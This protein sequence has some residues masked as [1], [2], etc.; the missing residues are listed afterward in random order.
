MILNF[1]LIIRLQK[2]WIL[3]PWHTFCLFC[4]TSALICYVSLNSSL[5]KLTLDFKSFKFLF[6]EEKVSNSSR[7]CIK[8]AGYWKMSL[9][10]VSL[11]AW[12]AGTGAFEILFWELTI[13]WEIKVFGTCSMHKPSLNE[14]R[15]YCRIEKPLI[16][17]RSSTFLIM[18]AL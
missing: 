13:V 14:P 12:I 9:E 18:A 15:I 8:F 10:N 16:F 4:L 17:P 2:R 7:H 1:Q 3:N 11:T 5:E 6:F